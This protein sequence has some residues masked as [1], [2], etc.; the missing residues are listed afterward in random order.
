ME[1]DYERRLRILAAAFKLRHDYEYFEIY[2][3]AFRC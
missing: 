3:K 1:L 2:E